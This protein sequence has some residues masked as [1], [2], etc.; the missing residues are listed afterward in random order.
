MRVNLARVFVVSG[1]VFGFAGA[2]CGDVK[3][4]EITEVRSYLFEQPV[5]VFGSQGLRLGDRAVATGLAGSGEPLDV[6]NDAQLNGTTIVSGSGTLRDRARVTGDLNLTGLLTRGFNTVVTGVVRQ[7]VAF[8]NLPVLFSQVI[9]AGTDAVN[10]PP[11]ANVSLRSG[12]YSS[13]VI[14][15]RST[16]RLSG[17]YDVT[18][19]TVDPDAR[20][21]EDPPGS[22][23]QINSVG[24]MSFADRV[25]LQA[26]DPVN[27]SLYSN[28]Q[29]VSIGTQSGITGILV[30]PGASIAVR[31]R[32]LVNGCVGGRQLT[33]EPDARIVSS[34]PNATLPL[35][36][37]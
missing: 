30:A 22:G 8:I 20:L 16:V 21:I 31:S 34:N 33:L 14:G 6:G 17:T 24:N 4:E 10:I 9:P 23:I 36:G 18:S 11:G 13:V 7:R 27:V 35:Q 26:T 15:A 1:L 19:W 37:T 5:C 2:G 12:G 3:T 25:V 28:G 32:A 29:S